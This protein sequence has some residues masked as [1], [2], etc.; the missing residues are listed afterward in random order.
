MTHRPFDHCATDY[1]Q[2][3]PTYPQPLMDHLQQ[4]IKTSP[5]FRV[6]DIGAGTGLF[7]HLLLQLGWPV[8]ALDPSLA[9]L[10]QM[11]PHPNLTRLLAQAEHLPLKNQSAN[12]I[13]VAQAF[14]WLNPPFA[15]REFAR[16]LS[17][18]G[19]LALCWNNRDLQFPFVAEFENLIQ[20]YNPVYQCEYRQQDWA[21]KINATNLFQ[22][23]TYL[24]FFHHWTIAHDNFIGFTRSL[25]YVRNVLSKPDR[26]AFEG[27]LRILI[28]HHFPNKPC[29]IPLRTELWLTQKIDN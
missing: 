24:E 20:E 22:K 8:V 4:A 25:S 29:K 14:H 16:A 3:R 11:K 5:S 18:D 6:I 17:P 28:N 1:A 10:T 19:Y 13:T 15:L 7:T 9:M 23:V 2:H 21:G 27:R 12:L 26:Q